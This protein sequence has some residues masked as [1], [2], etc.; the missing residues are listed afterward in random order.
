[1]L[2]R[3]AAIV[4]ALAPRSA[5][6]L[7]AKALGRR[8][9][10]RAQ[11]FYRWRG[12]TIVG[13][14]VRLR[15]GELD[16]VVRRGRTLVLVEVKTRQSLAAGEGFLAVDANKQ[17]R[18][19]RLGRELLATRGAGGCKQVRFDVVSLFWNGRRLALTHIADAFRVDGDASR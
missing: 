6:R 2:A 18:L 13:S 7:E 4:S 11:W 19:A 5:H 8:G 10:R 9:E 15:S 16:L 17:E 12:Y 14:N 1:M 3:I